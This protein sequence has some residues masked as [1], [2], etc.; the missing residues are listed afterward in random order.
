MFILHPF[1]TSAAY[2][3]RVAERDLA[4]RASEREE[5]RQEREVFLAAIQSMT[6]TTAKAFE[7][8]QAQ[9]ALFQKFLDSFNVTEP[10]R[11]REWDEEADFQRFLDKQVARGKT[12][13]VPEL[14]GLDQF[15]AFSAVLNRMEQ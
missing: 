13:G 5:R 6:A 3:A 8:Q 11:I 4:I 10:P 12:G 9:A 15:E 1:R 14:A 2:R 7:A